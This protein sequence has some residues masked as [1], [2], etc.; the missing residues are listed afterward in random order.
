MSWSQ[1]KYNDTSEDKISFLIN[2]QWNGFDHFV[3]EKVGHLKNNYLLWRRRALFAQVT[4]LFGGV[5][6]V[7]GGGFPM[8]ELIG[9]VFA[10]PSLIVVRI[11]II[12]LFTVGISVWVLLCWVK[13]NREFNLV[14]NPIVFDKAFEMLGFNGRHQSQEPVSQ[15][16]TIALLDHSELITEN[17]NIYMVDDMVVSEY[18][19]RPLCMYELSVKYVTGTG[20]NRRTK[21]VFHGILVTHDLPKTLTG[22]TFISTEADKKGFGK[23]SWWRHWF[24]KK[25]F[26]QE[27]FL[28]WNDFENKLHVA[29]TNA[30]EARYI[31]TPDFMENLYDWWTIRKGKIRISFIGNK[32]YV[33]Y[34]DKRVKIGSSTASLEVVDLKKYVLEVTRPLWHVKKLMECTEVRFR[35]W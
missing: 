7:T 13:V 12:G 21:A 18:Q 8:V 22:K 24:K 31:L 20:K 34:P 33:L 3:H 17:R 6:I 9:R 35:G 14:F 26:P 15:R 27:T 1:K 30:S 19:G 4:L 5:I 29:T 32:L 2:E 11:F 10:F 16:E 25:E 23:L 28:E